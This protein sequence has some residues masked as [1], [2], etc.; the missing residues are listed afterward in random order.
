M[1]NLL[2]FL[3]ISLHSFFTNP[4]L[5][6]DYSDPD[7]IKVGDDFWMTAS[8]FN[9]V[10][11]LPILHSKDLIH[12]TL[13]NAALP[14]LYS[15]S[16]DA[17]S[18]GN[19][20]W[21]P[22]IRFHQ[23]K[24]Y[25]FWGDPDIGIFVVTADNPLGEWSKPSLIIEGKGLIDPC[26]LWDDDGRLYLVHGWAGSRAGFKSILTICELNP[27]TFRQIG[28]NILAFN[29]KETGN[30][31]V[32]GPK[33]YK[34]DGWYYIFAPAGG[35]KEGW[36]LV[37]RSRDVFGPYE[38]KK[39]L[40]QGDSD[41]H[42]PHQGGWVEDAAGE[43]WFLHFEDRYAYG[44]V[45]H[46][47][48]M[49]WLPDGWCSIGVDTNGDGIGE[50]VKKFKVPAPLQG[51]MDSAL[52]CNNIASA[53]ALSTT[54]DFSH[55]AIPLNW[56]W[57]ANPQQG[58]CFLVPS[59]KSL[60][61]NCIKNRDGWRNLWDTPNLLLEKIVGSE[62]EFTTRISFHPSYE[63]DRAGIVV[64]GEDYALIGLE[65]RDGVI[66]LSQNTCIDASKGGSEIISSSLP[67]DK[68]DLILRITVSE[69]AVCD[70][71]YSTDGRRFHKF[72]SRF[73]AKAGRWIGAK[74]GYYATS[75]IK[76]NDGGYAN[77]SGE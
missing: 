63:G 15:D 16:F 41:I 43:S 40:H 5:H 4:I 52:T 25:I 6:S 21:A 76:K 20:V 71:Y 67:I 9:C 66:S 44:R 18:H 59:D 30:P 7:V 10:P 57:H 22:A 69:G 8:S 77:V 27:E 74:I 53:D 38:W 24:F 51:N 58:W 60:R 14:E 35:V 64:M 68:S 46:L 23:E 70:F 17:P 42:G 29:G 26:P 13:V 50:P 45:V 11:G 73:T 61:L 55:S 36:Q 12:W 1:K 31:T 49:Q 3:L 28:E 65:Y 47:Q 75:E 32:E 19:G 72:G 34:R 62:M 33:F 39:V 54:P 56:Q 48:P 37:L 2:L